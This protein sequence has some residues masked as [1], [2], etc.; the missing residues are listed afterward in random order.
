ME[1]EI[2]I[3]VST[4]DAINENVLENDTS[5]FLGGEE[6]HDEVATI[7]AMTKL[8]KKKKAMLI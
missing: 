6:I 4:C 3:L 7:A 1:V 8:K 2:T 5:A